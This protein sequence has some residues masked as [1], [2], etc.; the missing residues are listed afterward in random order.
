M[1]AAVRNALIVG[2]LLLTALIAFWF[3]RNFEKSSE[4]IT[5]PAY[6][7]PTYNALYALRET[8][9]RDGVKAETRRKLDL[10][11]MQ[12]Q[13]GDSVLMLDDPRL[14]TPAQVESLLDW[15]QFGGHLL[16]RVP[17]A[18]E[19]LDG[20]EQGL[21]E[22]LGVVT[23][24][25]AAR[26]QVWQVPGQASHDEFCSGNRFTL[27]DRIRAELRW[28]DGGGD[29]TLA[30]ARLRYG[31]GRVDILGDMD[32][33]LNGAGAGDPGLRDLPHRDLARLMLAP[34]YGK[35]TMHLIYAME[36][37]S[38]W[39]TLFERGWP[40]WLPLLLALLAWLWMRCQ[41]F[42]ALLPS[43]RE[44]R[45]SL[46]EHVRASGEHLHRYRKS[47]LLYDAVRQAFLA[48]LRRRAP[49]A[50][51]LTGEAQA[52]AIADHL[53]WPISRVQTALQIPPS[54]DDIALRDRIRL[55]IQM[56]NQL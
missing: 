49:V 6:G 45:R 32:F 4:E 31:L 44:D 30:Y 1:N 21:L 54:Q 50:A 22:R 17:D 38:L 53:Q 48:R 2:L 46:L 19:D 56:R 25:A 29:D 40:V 3:F 13:P 11:A 52:Q 28:A 55:L 5:L 20:D 43:P 23:S 42:G 18:D 8:L 47:P 7:E 24:D 10:P 27:T 15:V 51:A 35:G 16:L 26:C 37:P 14:L 36:L 41:R 9:I 12:L 39:K 33:L 34:N